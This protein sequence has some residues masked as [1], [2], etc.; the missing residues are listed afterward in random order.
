M[1]SAALVVSVLPA[2]LSPDTSTVCV[3]RSAKCPRKTRLRAKCKA[4]AH[5]VKGEGNRP[6]APA[7]LATVH[8]VKGVGSPH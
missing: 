2:P 1:R 7:H 4:A 8:R 5:R 3:T 6:D